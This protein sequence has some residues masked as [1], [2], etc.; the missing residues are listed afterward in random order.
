V[1]DLVSE[2]DFYSDL[3]V[4]MSEEDALENMTRLPLYSSE[5]HCASLFLNLLARCGCCDIRTSYLIGASF[6]HVMHDDAPLIR[7]TRLATSTTAPL[8]YP[9]SPSLNEYIYDRDER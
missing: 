9:S 2:D 1:V 5:I 8:R 3:E 6:L 7:F 4:R